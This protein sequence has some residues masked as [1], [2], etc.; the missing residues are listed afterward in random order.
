MSDRQLF[1]TLRYRDVEAGLAF[2]RAVGFSE[3]LVVRSEHDP[4]VV[5]H[6]Q[7]DWRDTGGVMAGSAD[8]PGAERFP[9]QPGTARGYLVVGSDAEVDRVYAAALAAGGTPLIEPVDEDY[10]GRGCAVAD[11]EGNLWS[12]GSYAGE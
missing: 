5:E 9:I 8:R 3:T 10:G 2:L 11:P 4:T 12:F 1:L 6:A 7:L